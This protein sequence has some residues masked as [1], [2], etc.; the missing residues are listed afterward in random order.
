[1]LELH[2]TCPLHDMDFRSAQWSLDPDLKTITTPSGG[3]ELH[4]NVHVPCPLCHQTHTYAPN[5]LACPLQ[6]PNTAQKLSSQSPDS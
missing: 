3:K 2:F 4:G 1:M 5:E 6:D